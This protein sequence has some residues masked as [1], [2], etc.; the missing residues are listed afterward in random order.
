MATCR[1]CD[2]SGW[3]LLVGQDG[4]CEGCSTT[5]RPVMVSQ[6]RSVQAS[7]KKLETAK[8]PTVMVAAAL[9]AASVCDE[10]VAFEE[11]RI[12]TFVTPPSR[13]ARQLRHQVSEYLANLAVSLLADAHLKAGL[14]T[15]DAA[16]VKPF[17]AA[18]SEIDEL[19]KVLPASPEIDRAAAEVRRHMDRA[20]FL[21]ALRK[22]EVAQA[23][24][25][26]KKAADILVAAMVQLRQD[27]TDDAQQ[28]DLFETGRRLLL[29][30]GVPAPF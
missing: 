10:L 5:V 3:L 24:N 27:G 15:T 20:I 19:R 29:D 4:F 11:K 23:Q 30:L 16:R 6:I 14:A 25:K 1:W 2:R 26:T 17:S 28:K 13:L 18:A 9:S 7:L 8:K 12:E 21:N 22:A